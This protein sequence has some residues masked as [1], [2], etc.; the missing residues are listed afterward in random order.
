VFAPGC[1]ALLVLFGFLFIVP[2]FFAHVMVTA[3]AKLGLSTSMALLTLIGI[4]I[5]GAINIPVKRIEREAELVYNPF[6]LY[7]LGRVMSGFQGGWRSPFRQRVRTYTVI[8]INVG[9]C[10][11]PLGIA[12]YEIVQIIHRSPQAALTVVVIT[13][14]NV[15][16]CYW[17]ARPIPNVGIAMPTLVPPLAAAIP[18]FLLLPQFAPPIAFVAG[19]LGPLIGADLLHL[20]EVER[21]QTGVVSIGGAGTFDGIV[22]SGM[23]AALLA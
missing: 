3:L 9:G 18:S 2:L 15:G 23:F 7:G 14:L 12:V 4:F 16:V 1:L 5:G 22:L 13:A 20:D 17:L 19:V 8:A 10:L 11:I 6:H 21:L